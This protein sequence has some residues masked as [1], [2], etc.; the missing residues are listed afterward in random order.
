AADGTL[1]VSGTGTDVRAYYAPP[2]TGVAAS[3]PFSFRLLAWPNPSRSEMSLVTEIAAD[4]HIYDVS[5]VLVRRLAAAP[6]AVTGSGQA[7]WDR[8][9][10]R[11]RPVPAGIYYATARAGDRNATA[12][13]V[14][15]R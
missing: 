5:G 9:D 15:I 6:G 10:D 2:A 14:V 8:R 4:I 1:I 7:V 11:G 13:L 3:G 12:R